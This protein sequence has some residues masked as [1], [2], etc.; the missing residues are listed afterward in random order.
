MLKNIIKLISIISLTTIMSTGVKAETTISVVDWQGGVV[1]IT[2]SYSEFI[3]NFEA[4]NPGVT[5][6]YT[7]YTVAT[8]NEF[9]KPAL[10]SGAGP[11]IFA[12]YPGPDI[13]E[14][15]NAGHLVDL[16]AA[17]DSE[18]QSWLGTSASIPALSRNGALLVA[19]QDAFTE[20]L[21]VYKDMI[22]D[23]GF[24]LPAFGDSYTVDE[25]IE[26][27]A[28]AKSKGLDGLMFG[29]V[30]SWCVWDGFYNM[31]NQ[32][33]PSYPE[34]LTNKALNGEISWDQD[35]FRQPLEAYK[36]MHEA[37]V[38]RADSLGMDYQVQAW[39]KWLDREGVGIYCNG[40]WF[41]ASAPAEHNSKDNANIF[42]MSYPKI[43]ANV[44]MTYNKATGTNLG[45][46]AN[47]ANKDMALKFVR[48]TNSP[49]ASTIFAKNGVIPVALAAM[50]LD[51]LAASDNPL[52]NDGIKMLAT[53]GRNTEIY[54]PQA[55]AQKALY[56]GIM[57]I[58]LG[59]ASVD[60]VINKMNEVTGY[61]G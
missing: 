45:V 32:L 56:D 40:D 41:T 37:G 57:E 16:T 20:E 33:N 36:K 14:V 19:P 55:E 29:P 10:S 39:G 18:W 58:F 22:A 12:V 43:N 53:E 61:G 44:P 2:D 3:K 46:N 52:F 42:M 26:I 8:Y 47:S 15:N 6:E 25:W 28:A 48:Y 50:D 24:E 35:M 11:D 23:L 30:E 34:D 13:D 49:E 54:Y 17:M 7:Q 51:I 4:E 59:V 1:G 5:V 21:W 31:A 27:S 9:L 60:D 38:W